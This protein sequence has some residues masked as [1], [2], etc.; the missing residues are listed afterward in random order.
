MRFISSA[1]D[2]PAS[3]PS[4][5]PACRGSRK[6]VVADNSALASARVQVLEKL[7]RRRWRPVASRSAQAVVTAKIGVM[8]EGGVGD[9]GG[10]I[11]QSERDERSRRRRAEVLA[12]P[13]M[14]LRLHGFLDRPAHYPNGPA[15]IGVGPDGNAVAAWPAPDG[16]RGVVITSYDGNG[17]YSKER[18]RPRVR[19]SVSTID[20]PTFLAVSHVQ[21]LPD[22]K[23]L[24]ACART[25]GTDNAE[26]WAGSGHRE[27]AGLIGDAIEHLLA[28]PSGA[29]WVGYFDEGVYGA[30]PAAHGL[31]RF[32]P[33]RPACAHTAGSTSS[34]LPATGLET[35]D[36]CLCAAPPGYSSRANGPP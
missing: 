4:V 8:R 18:Y 7:L 10:R 31:V 5:F 15:A 20:V 21:P 23:V 30:K 3:A 17:L 19:L 16:E 12:L 34:Q 32:T 29:I 35:T 2:A 26:V 27:R 24:I 6:C 14:P 1:R 11:T 22:G 13:M 25:Q 36:R 9:Q 28:T 33:E